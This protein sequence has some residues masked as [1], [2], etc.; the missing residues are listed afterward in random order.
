[1]PNI[2]LRFLRFL[3]DLYIIPCETFLNYASA[4]CSRHAA[5]HQEGADKGCDDGDKEVA[6]FLGG[7]ISKYFHGSLM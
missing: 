7:N 4:G 1:V 5:L 6:E 3:R 2:F